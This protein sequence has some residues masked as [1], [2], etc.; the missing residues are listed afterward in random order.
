MAISAKKIE[1]RQWST[2]YRG[3]VAIHSAKG[4]LNNADLYDECNKAFFKG[5][6]W[7]KSY[8]HDNWSVP[9]NI[10]PFGC[11]IAVG[12]LSVCRPTD[13][14]AYI[15]NQERAFGNYDPG[16]FGM[17]FENVV[18]LKEP[19]PW[20]SRQGKLLELDVKTELRLREQWNPL[21]GA[22]RSTREVSSR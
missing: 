8:A 11:I 5:A 17:V 20:K 13:Y 3:P 10:F 2:D 22:N 15:S 7:D 14:F 19:I 4:G 1:T 21:T 18:K 6:L 12:N 9:T 16:R